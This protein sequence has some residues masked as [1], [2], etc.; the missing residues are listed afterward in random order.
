MRIKEL[1][2]EYK[3]EH[4]PN[5]YIV[6]RNPSAT[7]LANLVN[8]MGSLRGIYHSGTNYVW[9]AMEGVH[10]HLFWELGLDEHDPECLIYFV[11]NDKN[12]SVDWTTRL[13]VAPAGF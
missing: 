3:V 7:E 8:R 4:T 10:C 13:S 12:D 5:G 2:N 6:F 9:G 11:T 1:L